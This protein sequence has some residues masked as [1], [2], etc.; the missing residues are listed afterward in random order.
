[1]FK[2]FTRL[3][4]DWIDSMHE[5]GWQKLSKFDA[6]EDQMEHKTIGYVVHESKTSLGVCQSYGV[7][8]KDPTIDSVMQIP[9]KA[10]RRTK[11]I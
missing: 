4:I 3:E 7:N 10:I 11:R 5:A 1:M 6:S 9:K 8:R 2:Q